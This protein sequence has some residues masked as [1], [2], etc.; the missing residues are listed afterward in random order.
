MYTTF[1][2]SSQHAARTAYT[3]YMHS[4][5]L[6]P[7]YPQFPAPTRCRIRPKP[8]AG[9]EQSM[10]SMMSMSIPHCCQQVISTFDCLWRQRIRYHATSIL[11]RNGVQTRR[12]HI[13][14]VREIDLRTH[15]RLIL[16]SPR[17]IFCMVYPLPSLIPSCFVSSCY[18]R[19]KPGE[20][21]TT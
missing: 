21:M 8:P 17:N 5:V 16:V 10:Y 7:N 3:V 11:Y 14:I 18:S 19:I 20:K 2:Y 12:R 9:C 6:P 15:F 1:I 13:K 4:V